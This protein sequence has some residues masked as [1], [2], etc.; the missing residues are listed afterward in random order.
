M[1]ARPQV[2]ASD[3][4]QRRGPALFVIVVPAQQYEPLSCA[5]LVMAL[6]TLAR[7]S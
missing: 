7:C 5:V 4:T 1:H 6:Q 3:K 2:S